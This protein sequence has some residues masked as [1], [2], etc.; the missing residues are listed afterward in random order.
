[1]LVIREPL[2]VINVRAVSFEH[3]SA[4]ISRIALTFLNNKKSFIQGMFFFFRSLLERIRGLN[5]H[6]KRSWV[7]DEI[8]V[9][10]TF[11]EEEEEKKL[12]ARPRSY[13]DYTVRV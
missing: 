6:L 2:L 5:W 3:A 13:G 7:D 8:W 10:P 12:V 1:M 9:P 4:S 11:G